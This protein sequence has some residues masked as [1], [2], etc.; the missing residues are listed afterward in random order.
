M[1]KGVVLCCATKGRCNTVKILE[2]LRLG[3]IR[4]VESQTSKRYIKLS[5]L[6]DQNESDLKPLLTD[7]AKEIFD[8]YKDAQLE[9]N[10]IQAREEFVLG[11]RLGSKITFEVMDG[12]EIPHIDE[13]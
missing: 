9:L 7:E 4:P 12:W 1:Q 11:F 8:K 5:R 13:I 3:N 2:E 10:D 6:A